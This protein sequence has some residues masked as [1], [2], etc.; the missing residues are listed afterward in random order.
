M[1]VVSNK[2]SAN[3]SIFPRFEE[4]YI[5]AVHGNSQDS[6]AQ[7]LQSCDEALAS[8]RSQ[9]SPQSCLAIDFLTEVVRLF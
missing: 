3:H 7:F 6:L 9:A 1:R 4:R 5:A 2:N 8:L